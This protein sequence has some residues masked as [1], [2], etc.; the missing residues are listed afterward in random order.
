VSFLSGDAG[1]NSLVFCHLIAEAVCQIVPGR[2]I[3][4]VSDGDQ[5]REPE[6]S[7]D[8]LL[9]DLVGLLVVIWK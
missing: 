9:Q 5:R 6:R 1:D 3:L 4:I 2:D 8:L 7:V